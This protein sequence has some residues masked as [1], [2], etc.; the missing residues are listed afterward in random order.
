MQLWIWQHVRI[1]LPDDWEMLRFSRDGGQGRCAFAD[2]YQFR[3]ELSWRAG[4]PPDMARLASDYLS[5]LKLDGAM[6]D[7]TATRS[8]GW[9]GIEGH[10]DGLATTRFARYLV[11]EHCLVET[12]FLWPGG[13]D[14]PLEERVLASVAAEAAQRGRFQRWKAF[15]MDALVTRGL[16]LQDCEVQ[17]ASARLTFADG[18]EAR[19]E[20]FLRLGMVPEW[21]QGSVRDWLM[22]Q[23][24]RDV[25]LAS[26]TA[27][28]R[29]GHAIA[30][31][32]GSRR[33]T[34]VRRKSRYEAAA[35]LCPA[36]GRLY[37]VATVG[38]D[39]PLGGRL[40]CCGHMGLAR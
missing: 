12:V 6:P 35:W 21:L 13:R 18:R 10:Q 5:K 34:L 31:V 25:A 9:Q 36:D 24:P 22:R 19:Q 1:E 11:A 38:S 7:A 2:R 17:P 28:D 30:S 20:T 37:C 40:S 27:S 29:D 3:L 16:A 23:K 15:G 26:E 33:A 39:E 8:D 14:L 4:G 32:A